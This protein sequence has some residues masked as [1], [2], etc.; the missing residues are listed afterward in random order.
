[1]STK[2]LTVIYPEGIDT[3]GADYFSVISVIKDL[4]NN[5]RVLGIIKVDAAYSTLLEVI[6][7]INLG[8]KGGIK[9]CT[10]RGKTILSTLPEDETGLGNTVVN[11]FDLK[12]FG[13]KM[14]AIN[15]LDE[16]HALIRKARFMGILISI[17]ITAAV[18]ILLQ[19][20]ITKLFQPMNEVIQ[21]MNKIKSGSRD[22]RYTDSRH[23]EIGYLGEVLND[24]LN[25]LDTMMDSQLA[26]EHRIYQAQ[27][28][29]RDIKLHL[30][31]GQIRPHFI[32]NTLNTVSILIQKG[33]NQEAIELLNRFSDLLRGIAY[34]DREIP[35]EAEMKLTETYLSIQSV[36][37]SDSLTY[38]IC[39]DDNSREIIV[40]AL[41]LQ[42]LVE[43]S[44]LHGRSGSDLPLHIS[45]K[46]GVSQNKLELSVADNGDGIPKEKLTAI[47]QNIS[48]IS[49]EQDEAESSTSFTGNSDSSGLGLVNVYLRLITHYGN[50]CE[51][52]IKSEE[53]TGTNVT[54]RIPVN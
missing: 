42:P 24:M 30:L 5:N 40:P 18:G 17:F 4:Y 49:S 19:Y 41:I 46:S 50:H 2:K 12:N 23:D 13:W 44:I 33:Q 8:T 54:I 38:D 48:R 28:N 51:M 29:E 16:M 7:N 53:K 26:L 10:D 31:Y 15:S 32:Y 3:H 20:T 27:I 52:T 36:R 22:V 25:Q 34:I 43:N 1:M 9:I 21:L 39:M 37:F 35:M 47:T 11:S 6:S 45:V 14:Y